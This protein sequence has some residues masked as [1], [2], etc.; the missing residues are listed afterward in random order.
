MPIVPPDSALTESQQLGMGIFLCM[1][2]IAAIYF[3]TEAYL[4]YRIRTLEIENKSLKDR[5][6]SRGK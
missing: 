3:I 1:V 6:G 4:N 2:I 5:L